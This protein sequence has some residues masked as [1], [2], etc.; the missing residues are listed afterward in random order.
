MGMTSLSG[1]SFL[2]GLGLSIFSDHDINAIHEASLGVLSDTGVF[3]ENDEALEI[4]YSI[5][6]QVDQKSKVAKIPPHLAEE[7]VDSIPSNITLGGRDSKNDHVMGG[8]SLSFSAFGEATTVRDPY[9][10]NIRPS[11][12]MDVAAA[13]RIQHSLDI[14]HTTQ[15]AVSSLDVD[16]KVMALHNFEA[17]IHNTTKPCY[18]SAESGKELSRLYQMVEV[19]MGGREEM[20]QRPLVVATTC[21]VSPLRIIHESCEIIMTAARENMPT[22]FTTLTMAGGT[23]P[24][25]LAGTMVVQ[26]TEFLACAVLHQAVCKGA[27]A[28]RGSSTT[29]MDLK[30]GATAV[31]SPELALLSAFTARLC[32]LY[33]IPSWIAGG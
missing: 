9:S 27:P 14:A 4:L 8:S 3:F 26:N 24:I 2:D 18:I 17:M 7:A 1:E 33:K 28:V 13:S 23:G 5:G 22:R 10:L 30:L 25:T 20:V 21:P 29:C 31:G 16:P 32:K 15:R 19:V 6:C 11:S 12:K